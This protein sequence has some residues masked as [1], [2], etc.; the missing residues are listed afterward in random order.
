MRPATDADTNL[1][2]RWHRDPE[3]A[4]YWDNE[5]FTHEEMRSRLARHNVDP[6]IVEANGEP[7]GYLQAWFGDEPE[8]AGLDMFLVPAAR[9]R[10]FGPD[11]ARALATYLLQETPRSALNVDPYL[12]NTHAI[13]AWQKAGFR[14]VEERPPDA[15]H[16]EAWLFMTTDLAALG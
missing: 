13:L 12:S 4:R 1:L 15:D 5:T 9:G 11:A 16:T 10:G 7:I 6:Y 8:D 14:P 3:I 2:V